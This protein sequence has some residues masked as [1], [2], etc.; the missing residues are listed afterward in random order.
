[1]K[2]PPVASLTPGSVYSLYVLS[3]DLTTTEGFVTDVDVSGST[4]A[5]YILMNSP[6]YPDNVSI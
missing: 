2:F 5:P 6:V 4:E 3:S 1:M